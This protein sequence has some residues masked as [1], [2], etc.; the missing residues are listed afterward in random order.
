M[1]DIVD[2]LASS[3]QAIVSSLVELVSITFTSDKGKVTS[4]APT[5]QVLLL[6]FCAYVHID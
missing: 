3:S 4:A 6:G 5:R 2:H 1:F